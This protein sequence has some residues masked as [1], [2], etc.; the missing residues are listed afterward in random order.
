M[1]AIVASPVGWPGVEKHEPDAVLF[2]TRLGLRPAISEIGHKQGD[3]VVDQRLR[4]LRVNVRQVLPLDVAQNAAVPA[5]G[6]TGVG[7]QAVDR[8]LLAVGHH[9]DPLPLRAV[10]RGQLGGDLGEWLVAAERDGAF[11]EPAGAD[12]KVADLLKPLAGQGFDRVRRLGVE[13]I[14]VEDWNARGQNAGVGRQRVAFRP[15]RDL[16]LRHAVVLLPVSQNGL[17][18][19]KRQRRIAG[20]K[21]AKAEGFDRRR[22]RLV[23]V[24]E[25][26][27]CVAWGH[28]GDRVVGHAARA[29]SI[30]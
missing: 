6:S 10:G 13:N 9:L 24:L 17:L 23:S 15:R 26:L 22:V 1:V 5:V 4:L 29:A 3:G 14:N 18:S 8:Q 27:V 28:L 19:G 11:R 16:E 7:M 2:R 30:A 21:Q 25:D 20:G 12:Q